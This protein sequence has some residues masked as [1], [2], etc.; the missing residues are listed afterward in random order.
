MNSVRRNGIAGILGVAT[1]L[2]F[3]GCDGLQG[4]FPRSAGD[5]AE[6]RFSI[7]Q[8]RTVARVDTEASTGGLTPVVGGAVQTVHIV[9]ADDAG[10]TVPWSENS[11]IEWDVD[12]ESIATVTPGTTA[13]EFLVQ[14]HA[15]GETQAQ[16]S[17]QK[18]TGAGSASQTLVSGSVLLRTQSRERDLGAIL[19]REGCQSVASY[20]YSPEFGAN[21][22]IGPL[23]LDAGE[24]VET[25]NVIFLEAYIHN[26]VERL[27]AGVPDGPFTLEVTSSAPE[28]VAAHSVAG[29]PFEFGLTAGSSGTATLS[30]ELRFNGF[31]WAQYPGIPVRVVGAAEGDLAPRFVLQESGAWRVIVVDGAV[32][33]AGGCNFAQNPGWIDTI[34]EQLTPHFS[35]RLL[36]TN[37]QR[38]FPDAAV[39]QVL[40]RFDDSCI[41]RSV[42]HP[43]HWG[44]TVSFH[45]T[46]VIPGE[47]MA[48]AYYFHE[49]QFVFRSPRFSVKVTG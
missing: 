32:P 25:F 6:L 47:T 36:D 34:V 21:E 29:G 1:L 16:V 13:G 23:L 19:V 22:A 45:F 33:P 28:V 26:H 4:V 8:D 14:A 9:L 39:D 35:I 12:D 17:L 7:D 18:T 43:Q 42:G 37:C 31:P 48:R 11:T 38:V 3:A 44:G 27:L 10:N 5:V 49:G 30:F 40:F 15:L 24:T 46:E 2:A 41:A 20:N